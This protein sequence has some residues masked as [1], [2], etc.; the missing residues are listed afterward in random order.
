[1]YVDRGEL[2][3]EDAGTAAV[4]LRIIKKSNDRKT[5]SLLFVS[6]QFLHHDL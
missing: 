2:P 3:D 5:P 6:N 1:L 4:L